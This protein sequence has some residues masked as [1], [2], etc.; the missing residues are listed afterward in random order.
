M[1][2]FFRSSKQQPTRGTHA[3]LPRL[4]SFCKKRPC[5]GKTELASFFHFTKKRL[6]PL[7]PRQF[8]GIGFVSQKRYRPGRLELASF[9]RNA[10]MP[11]HRPPV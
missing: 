1:G 3:T 7:N 9:L 6:N 11:P 10:K 4:A 5:D 8:L 2:S